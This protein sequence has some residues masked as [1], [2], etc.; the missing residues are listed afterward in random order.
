VPTGPK[1]AKSKDFKTINVFISAGIFFCCY[2][3]WKI[4]RKIL[5]S[6]IQLFTHTD[7]APSIAYNSYVP[8]H[9]DNSNY[10]SF[11]FVLRYPQNIKINVKKEYQQD[12]TI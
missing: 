9:S 11:H 5:S 1:Y 4:K 6:Q 3:L 2:T 8:L 10:S 7:L 12:A